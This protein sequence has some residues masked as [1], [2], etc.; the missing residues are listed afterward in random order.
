MIRLALA[1]FAA[2]FLMSSHADAKPHR[3]HHARQQFVAAQ[4]NVTQ[5]CGD[6]VCGYEAPQQARSPRQ[7]RRMQRL[8]PVMQQHAVFMPQ[9]PAQAGPVAFTSTF[10]P[11]RDVGNAASG[12][13]AIARSQIG[14]GAIYG[15]SNL[16]CARFMNVVLE[17]AGV[18]GTGTDL[19]RDFAHWGHRIAGPVVGAIAV[20]G[21]RG[22]DHVGVVSGIDER[23]N[24]IIISG[25]HGHRVAEAKY[26]RGR[27]YAY[28]MP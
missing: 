19:A 14:N 9:E 6:R 21:R 8:A 26:S 7:A 27:I 5:F 23:G 17:R 16:W 10:D 18:R 24:P 3:Q 13:V 1:A 20:M 28:V 12:I 4:S 15:R 2:V 22:G 11:V 25:N